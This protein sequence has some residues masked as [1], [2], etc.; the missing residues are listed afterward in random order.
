MAAL[1]QSPQYQ[2]PDF[3]AYLLEIRLL[4]APTYT[5]QALAQS[6]T[7]ISALLEQANLRNEDPVAFAQ[8]DW[9][10]HYLLTQLAE[11]PVFR[12]LLNSFESLYALMAERYFSF[13]ECRKN[14]RSFYAALL[15]C[16]DDCDLAAAETLT[17]ETMQT[18]LDLWQRLQGGSEE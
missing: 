10:L 8:F 5:R 9:Q 18:S 14:S 4:L 17:R 13:E 12:L 11:N 2:S 1:A 3:V 16:T 6:C 7:Q 15:V